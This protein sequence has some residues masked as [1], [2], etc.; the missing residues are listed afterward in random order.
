MPV[1]LKCQCGKNL[2]VP[3]SLAGKAV[4]CP[5]CGKVLKVPAGKP[6]AAAPATAPARPPARAASSFDGDSLEDLFNEEG[7]NQKV[8]AI[9]PACRGDIKAGAVLCTKCGFNLQ[10][11][12]RLE[13]F[14]VKGIDI[15]HG[16][17]ALQKAS[18]DLAKSQEMQDKMLS[19]A[20]MPW[21]MLGLVLVLLVGSTLIAVIA[22]NVARSEQGGNFNPIATF[23]LLAGATCTVI[24]SGASLMLLVRA[25]QK[26]VVTGLLVWLVPFYVFYFVYQYPRDTWKYLLTSIMM[27][28][29]GG[30]LIGVALAMG[31]A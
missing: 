3:D 16:T 1:R 15:S 22:I 28:I 13:G 23:V 19:K 17:L 5:G 12:E 6:Q 25:F 29:I 18:E 31:L 20:G 10:T 7:F 24:S 27:G 2:N 11:G 4:K 30:V 8:E 26:D 14:K 21:W 9:C